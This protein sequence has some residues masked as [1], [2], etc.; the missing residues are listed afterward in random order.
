[1]SVKL[2]EDVSLSYQ[3]SHVMLLACD[4]AA[5]SR[6]MSAWLCFTTA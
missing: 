6:T 1:M 5:F 2:V 3:N 4:D